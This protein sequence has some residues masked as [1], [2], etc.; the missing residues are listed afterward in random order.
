MLVQNLREF[1]ALYVG[2]MKSKFIKLS[3]RKNQ[4]LRK[5]IYAQEFDIQV[6]RGQMDILVF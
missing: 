4:H 6:F 5:E 2:K 3:A 1:S